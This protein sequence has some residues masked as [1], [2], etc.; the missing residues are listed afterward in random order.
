MGVLVILY[1]HELNQFE[2]QKE[3]LNKI[4]EKMDFSDHLQMRLKQSSQLK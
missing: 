4:N 3:I 1:V 2:L